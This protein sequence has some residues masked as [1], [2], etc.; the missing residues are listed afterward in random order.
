MVK[1]DYPITPAIRFLREKSVPFKTHVYK[2]EEHGGTGRGAS[3]LRMPEHMLIKTIVLQTDQNNVLLVLMHGDCE[4]STKQLA[5]T[6]NVKSIDPCDERTAG[7]HTG[8]QFGG[9]S[10]F[11]TRMRLPVFVEKTIFDLPFILINGGKRGFL[12]EIDPR[13]LRDFLPVTEVEAAI[14]ES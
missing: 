1:P 8:Y 12:V 2:Y 11:G 6:L 3:E 9:T 14:P 13:V 5:R 4:I 10:P 7:R